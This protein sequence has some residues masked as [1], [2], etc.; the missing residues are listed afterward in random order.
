MKRPALNVEVDFNVDA[1]WVT[2]I[3]DLAGY[4]GM[5]VVFHK[6]IRQAKHSSREKA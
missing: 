3:G 2:T 4:L 1:P 6:S 5:A